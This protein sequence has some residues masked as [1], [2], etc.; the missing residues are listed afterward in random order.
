VW[1]VSGIKEIRGLVE[2]SVT[3]MLD[4]VNVCGKSLREA[5]AADDVRTMQDLQVACAA[6]SVASSCLRECLVMLHMIETP[7]EREG[8]HGRQ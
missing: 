2:G 4:A 5:D 7:E 1:V 8:R 6:L 3:C